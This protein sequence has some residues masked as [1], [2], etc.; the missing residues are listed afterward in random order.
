MHKTF[1]CQKLI[2]AALSYSWLTEITKSKTRQGRDYC[3][4]T[5]SIIKMDKN[6]CPET[7]IPN[8]LYKF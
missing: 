7:V 1:A 4:S 3:I 8:V 5:N 6:I 2:K